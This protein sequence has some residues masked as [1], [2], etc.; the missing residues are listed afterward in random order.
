MAILGEIDGASSGMMP[1]LLVVCAVFIM[2]V[3][4]RRHQSGAVSKRGPARDHLAQIRDQRK[5]RNS[6]DDLL[7]QVEAVARRVGAEVET[8]FAKLETV[9]RDADE[10]INTL[11]RLSEQH[12]SDAGRAEQ[13]VDADAETTDANPPV[14]AP[15]PEPTS[16]PDTAVG[17]PRF[18][19][20][21]ALIDSGASTISA[22]EQLSL[23]LG[24]VELILNL[25][26][27]TQPPTT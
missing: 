22:A 26:G 8:R 6:M 5:L 23:P 10:R 16:T 13:P 11:R 7:L 4:L 2:I 15:S 1:L 21:Y 24:E 19:R 14:A 20:V 17:D 12:R 3:L 27:I 18:E 25:R 9:I